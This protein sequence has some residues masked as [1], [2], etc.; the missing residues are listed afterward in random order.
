MASAACM[1]CWRQ[2]PGHDG[3]VA[4]AGRPVAGLAQPYCGPHRPRS[5]RR[6]HADGR[7]AALRPRPCAGTRCGPQRARCCGARAGAAGSGV[8]DDGGQE[9]GAGP[10]NLSAASRPRPPDR[11]GKPPAT[12]TGAA[13]RHC[14]GH[15]RRPVGAGGGAPC[16]AGGDAAARCARRLA[17]A[18]RHRAAGQGGAGRRHRRRAG[19]Q[20]RHRDA[21]RAARTQ[22]AGQP[23]H[24]PDLGSAARPHG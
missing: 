10:A 8:P 15:C 18:G 7:T 4:H 21:G 1:R 6:K 9:H 5:C 12:G 24:L 2:E 16:V 22:F 17:G 13:R 14:A 11:P 20:A 23:R 19:R 3:T